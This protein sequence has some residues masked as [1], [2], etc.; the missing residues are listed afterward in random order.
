MEVLDN[1]EASTRRNLKELDR[2][3]QRDHP[4]KENVISLLRQTFSVRREDVLKEEDMS[5]A[6]ILG[7]HPVLSLPYA[8]SEG[9]ILSLLHYC[10]IYVH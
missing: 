7:V 4:R 6:A 2:E 3:L 8:V 9:P 5:V 1:D 10:I